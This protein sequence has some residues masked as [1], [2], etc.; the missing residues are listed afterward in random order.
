MHQ[1]RGN[2]KPHASD[3]RRPPAGLRRPLTA[4]QNL[5]E[6]MKRNTTPGCR[7][8]ALTKRLAHGENKRE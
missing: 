4:D 8:C 3:G 2:R 5:T 7:R 1:Q 6:Q